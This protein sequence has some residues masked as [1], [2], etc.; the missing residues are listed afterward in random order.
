L[1]VFHVD[2]EGICVEGDLFC[3]GSGSAL[4]YSVLDSVDK[5]KDISKE[6]AIESAV[7][8]VKHATHRDGFSGGYINVVE[9]NST[10]VFHLK[11]IDCR[12]LVV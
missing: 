7:W 8:A 11:R 4:A 1:I 9:V 10:G 5:L 3:V 2:S 12:T 6:K